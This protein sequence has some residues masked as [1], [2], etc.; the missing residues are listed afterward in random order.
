[1]SLIIS[2]LYLLLNIALIVLVAALLWWG[3]R[4][5]GIGIDPWVFKICQMILALLVLILIVSWL[6]GVIPV[7]GVFGSGRS[8]VP[9]EF[10]FLPLLRR[11]A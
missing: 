3:L 10:A 5:L 1:M 7:R 2:V 9:G 8:I 6:A 11:F 4:W